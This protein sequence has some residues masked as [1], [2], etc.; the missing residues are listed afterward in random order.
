MVENKSITSG[1]NEN[2]QVTDTSHGGDKH[3]ITSDFR[4]YAY[5]EDI[6]D[7]DFKS[8]KVVLFKVRWYI[9]FPQDDE[10]IVIDHDNGFIM[11]KTTRYDPNLDPFVLPN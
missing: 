2:F 6:L 5:L 9:F 4:Y 3:M 10:M 1:I 11:I 8:F 7:V